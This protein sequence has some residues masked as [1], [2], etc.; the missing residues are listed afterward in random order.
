MVTPALRKLARS[1]GV[2]TNYR[3]LDARRID[4]EPEVLVTVL[5]TL[6]ASIEHAQHTQNAEEALQRKRRA[7]CQRML[8]PVTTIWDGDI[9][10]VRMVLPAEL[11]SKSFKATLYLEDGQERDWSPSARTLVRAREVDGTR[12]LW[13]RLPL[14]SLPHGYH[15]L[16][17][18]MGAVDAETF[19]LCAPTRAY[20]DPARG[21]RWGL[22]APL[23][24][25]HSKHSAGI[26]NFGDLRRFA[27][28]T[29]AHGGRFIATLPL[30]ASY[31]DEPSPYSPASRLFW[32]ELYVDAGTAS[33]K[34][35]SELLDYPELYAAKR[36]TMRDDATGRASDVAAFQARFPLALD[37]ARFRAAA[38]AHGANWTQWPDKLR[39]GLIEE[40]EVEVEPNIDDD[41][42]RYHLYSQMLAEEQIAEIAAGNAELYFDLPLGVHRF[43]YDAWR[44][45]TLFAHDVDVGAP[46]DAAFPGGQNWSFPPVLPEKSRLQNHRHLRLVYRHAMRHADILRIDHVMGLHRQFWIPRGA[47]VADGVY[48]RYPAEEL[49]ATLNIESHRA[50]C[51]LVGENLG[52]VPDVVTKSLAQ[53]GFRGLYIAELTPDAPIPTGSVASLNTHDTELFA[54]SGADLETA[55][56]KLLK[57]EADLVSVTLEDL[58]NETSRQNVPGTKDEHPN[59]QRPLRHTLED[60]E[61]QLGA[62][63]DRFTRD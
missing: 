13:T 21:K 14:P 46:P 6:G 54:T 47:S 33:P 11:S 62:T 31:P 56:Q 61:A 42:V 12:Y 26:G 34:T 18:S 59:W 15:R 39:D 25:L 44:E 24:A 16:H 35:P 43:S 27:E 40:A 57:S 5:R 29:L 52:L 30:L 22:F 49:Y 36:H 32:N 4:A 58:W 19:I 7:S 20:R 53:H 2:Q 28:L 48:I 50:R 3:D 9:G 23:Y 1:Y 38:E 45:Q 8:E 10:G 17:V 37:Y 51:E 63:L 60:I 41:A 55:L